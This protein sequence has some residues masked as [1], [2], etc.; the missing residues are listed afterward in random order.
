MTEKVR[1]TSTSLDH[2]LVAIADTVR[3]HKNL[4]DVAAWVAKQGRKDTLSDVVTQDEYTHDV[5]VKYR[6]NVYL[7]YDVT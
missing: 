3:L 6:D 2:C 7:V 4:S 1:T 5:T